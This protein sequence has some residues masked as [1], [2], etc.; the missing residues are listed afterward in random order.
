L[1]VRA[2]NSTVKRNDMERTATD[3]LLEP[4]GVPKANFARMAVASK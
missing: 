4:E 3:K 1:Q 2:L